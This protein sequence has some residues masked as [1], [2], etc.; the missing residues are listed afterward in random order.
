MEFT[1]SVRHLKK[2]QKLPKSVQELIDKKVAKLAEVVPA[3]AKKSAKLELI[4][5]E[6]DNSKK[7]EKFHFEAKLN[8]PEKILISGV[9]SKSAEQ[10]IE[11]AEAKLLRQVRKYKIQHHTLK[12]M[13]KKTLA[14]LRKILKRG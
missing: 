9:S 2:G 10:A 4:L 1:L 8:L 11:K 14:K 7:G 5:D 13:D 3:H 12:K 6:A